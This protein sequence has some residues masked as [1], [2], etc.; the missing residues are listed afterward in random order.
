[1]VLLSLSVAGVGCSEED[2]TPLDLGTGGS[3][4]TTATAGGAG[5]E[6]A[7]DVPTPHA[8]GENPQARAHAEQQC[9]DDIELAQGVIRI[10]DP[11]TDTVVG[12]VI[13][14]CTEVRGSTTTLAVPGAATSEPAAS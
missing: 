14:E 13:V 6:A 10:V 8:V 5:P 4:A 12:E 11:A 7:S 1:M 3:S 2:A 9:L